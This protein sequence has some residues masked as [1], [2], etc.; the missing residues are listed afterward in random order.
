MVVYGYKLAT[1]RRSRLVLS[2]VLGQV[3]MCSDLRRADFLREAFGRQAAIDANEPLAH[4]PQ[5]CL[6]FL[7]KIPPLLG[8]QVEEFAQDLDNGKPLTVMQ[9]PT[10]VLGCQLEGEIDEVAD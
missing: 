8:A 9:A 10:A 3:G 6:G 1:I 5:L 2:D 4:W 7:G